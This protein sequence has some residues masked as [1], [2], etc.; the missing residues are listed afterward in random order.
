MALAARVKT[1]YCE[2]L[3]TAPACDSRM[4]AAVAAGFGADV[5]DEALQTSK[6]LALGGDGSEFAG[7]AGGRQR[8]RADP[9]QQRK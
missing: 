2:R 5:V 3:L 4:E 8:V 7:V 9:R 1:Y 6:R